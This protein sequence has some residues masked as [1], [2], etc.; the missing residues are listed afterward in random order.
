[1]A[2][3]W[4]S[5]T[6]GVRRRLGDL[7]PR[8][9]RALAALGLAVVA[10]GLGTAVFL[11]QSGL[12]EKESRNRANGQ[13]LQLVRE[14]GKMYRDRLAQQDE[15]NRRLATS[16][17]PLPSIVGEVLTE[18][19]Q[20]RQ[21]FQELQPEPVGLPGQKKKPWMRLSVKFQ[22]RKV[23]A[24]F[25]YE[26]LLKLRER[27]PELPL[28]VTALDMHLD[29]SET[30]LYSINKM[31]VSAYRLAERREEDEKPASDVEKAGAP[32]AAG[33]AP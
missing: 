27:Y 8:E 6:E 11:V 4:A 31:I 22:L 20:A 24:Q 33:G 17:P 16:M 28:A 15:L 14:K 7:A 23:S 25:V 32:A 29:Q 26:F 10:F 5:L 9:R 19:G 18:L 1:M 13:V 21:D 2:G 30:A 12:A 3:K